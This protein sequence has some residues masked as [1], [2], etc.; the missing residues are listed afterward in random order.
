M[1]LEKPSC[2]NAEEAA[3]LFNSPLLKAPDAP[4]LLEAFHSRFTPA[5][6]LFRES[7]DQPNVEHALAEAWLPAFIMGQDNIRFSYDL[8]GG[9]TMDVGT[10][11]VAALRS[12]F[13]AEPEECLEAHLTREPPPH[14]R[15]DGNFKVKLRFPGGGVGE[16]EGGLR[17]SNVPSLKW[18]PT[19]T[20]THRPVVV[21]DETVEEGEEV[22]KTRT[23]R[24][25][26]FMVSPVY[27]RIDITDEYV[28]SR[29]GSSEVVRKFTRKE[30]RKAYTY[31]EMGVDEPGEIHWVTYRHMLE[32]F[33]HR[34]RGRE[35][36]GPWVSHEDSIAQM[37][38]LDMIYNKSGLGLRPTSQYRPEAS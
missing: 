11:P 18:L 9:A 4:V 19:V 31:K 21:A 26:N 15:C 13:G 30:T 10:Y 38:A 12:V 33:V 36:T 28:V 1:L 17:G 29:K 5:W 23:V 7:L 32:Q 16:I 35:G 6:R 24:F 3:I 20:V 2:S 37:K 25:V 27:H 34:V 14:D 22:R 8:A